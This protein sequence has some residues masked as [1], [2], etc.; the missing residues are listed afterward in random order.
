MAADEIH[1]GDIGTTFRATI[2][3]D[4]SVIDISGA[5]TLQMIFEKP[6]GS[7][8]TKTATLYSDG[9][10]GKMQYATVSGDL[11]ETGSWRVQAYIALDTWQGKTDMYTFEVHPNL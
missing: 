7:T 8:M 9:T 10:D 2:Q 3:Q 6:S 11:D 1:Q 4:A 5:S